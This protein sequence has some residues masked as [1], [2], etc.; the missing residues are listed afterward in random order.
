[1]T[2]MADHPFHI[3][4]WYLDFISEQGEAMIFYAAKMTWHGITVPYTSRIYYHP[5]G[6]LKRKSRY[7]HVIMPEM[8]NNL[9][10]WE[11]QKSQ[12]SGT[13]KLKGHPIS[14]RLFDSTSGYLDWKCHQPA[15][16]VELVIN[17]KKI[18][19]MGYA[20]QLILTA[21]PWKIPMDELRWGRFGSKQDHVVW[22]EI[23][24]A[25]K[26]QWV[27]V[28][29]QRIDNAIVEDDHISFP[30]G[31]MSVTLDRKGSLE[32]EKTIFNVVEKLVKY[33]PGFKKII[34][35]HFLMADNYKWLSDATL[36]SHDKTI[37]GKA[38]H[39]LVAFNK[40]I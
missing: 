30:E 6:D 23:N 17:N 14:A 1:M 15:S 3:D 9:I 31:N 5:G 18:V 4:K 12:I 27:Y 22:I 21:P 13:W 11:D 7:H 39:E 35:I 38:I 25:D 37:E 24:G 2:D 26:Q 29:G 20:E 8:E 32:S 10:R 33:L 40:V 28:N 36:F 19:G 34:P 16:S